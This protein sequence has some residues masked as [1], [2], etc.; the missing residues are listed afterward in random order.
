MEV[1]I[2]Q[3]RKYNVITAIGWLKIKGYFIDIVVWHTASWIMG[4]PWQ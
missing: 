1:C 4:V 2:E 3:W